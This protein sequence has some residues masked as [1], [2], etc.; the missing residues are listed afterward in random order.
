MVMK[1]WIF[2]VTPICVV[3]GV[4]FSDITIHGNVFVPIVFA[5]MTFI[6]ALKSTFQDDVGDDL[7]WK[8]TTLPVAC[9]RGYTA[10]T[11]SYPSD[12]PDT[13]GKPYPCGY[14]RHDGETNP[15]DCSSC[16]TGDGV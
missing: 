15:Y 14:R 1:K 3:I 9:D 12:T 10:C 2:L 7:P 5:I 4:V 11:F 16:D 6:G 8:R 13:G